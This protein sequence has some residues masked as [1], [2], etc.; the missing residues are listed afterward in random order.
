MGKDTIDLFLDRR[1]ITAKNTRKNYRSHIKTYF[2]IIGRDTETYFTSGLKPKDYEDDL[3]KTHA[4]FQEIGKGEL[5]QRTY[6]NA[7]KMYLITNKPKLEQLPFWD[8]FTKKTRGAEPASDE[9]ILD[10][11]DIKR[12]LEHA[13]TLSR[14]MFLMQASSGRRLGEILALLPSDVQADEHPAWIS[15]TKSISNQKHTKNKHKTPRCYMSDEAAAAYKA[16]MLERPAYL[17]AAAKKPKTTPGKLQDPRVFPMTFVNAIMI[18][19]RLI[20][21]ARLVESETIVDAS[22][23]HVKVVP[24]RSHKYERLLQHPHGLRKFY[25]SYLGDT[26]LAEYLMGHM[27]PLTRAYEKLKP[28][29]LAER[30]VKCMG[31]VTIF[32]NVPDLS[33]INE[34]LK[35]KDRQI[36]EL[37]A[38]Y[39]TTLQAVLKEVASVNERNQRLERELDQLKKTLS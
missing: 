38:S 3:Y 8:I 25:R 28:E 13:N 18:W 11:E 9:A 6:F 24:K 31:N 16:W 30:Y 29:D 19:Q 17:I 36:E 35:E 34:R 23:R 22:G 2:N 7:V 5:S 14:A 26:D 32:E 27:T 39:S 12:I 37:Q 10:R 33:S 4:H 20:I 21:K 1:L 15:I